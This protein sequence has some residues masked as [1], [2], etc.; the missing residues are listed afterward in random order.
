MENFWLLIRYS[1]A[2]V[3]YDCK[4]YVCHDSSIKEIGQSFEDLNTY[5]RIKLHLEEKFTQRGLF[6][7]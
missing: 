1:Y 4:S 3:I 6:E 5:T 2:P 7:M